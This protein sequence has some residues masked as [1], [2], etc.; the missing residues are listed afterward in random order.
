M[1]HP[2]INT[3]C[4]AIP[5]QQRTV[6]YQRRC[7]KRTRRLHDPFTWSTTTPKESRKD[8]SPIFQLLESSTTP[9][10]SEEHT[11]ELQSRFDLVCR[12]L[13]D[14]KKTKDGDTST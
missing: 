11:S 3:V 1:L 5:P 4:S 14:K 8:S 2:R 13:L 7:P 9:P 10:R 6:C 12:L